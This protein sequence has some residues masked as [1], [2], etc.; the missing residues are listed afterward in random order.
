MRRPR[1]AH[2]L[3]GKI[4]KGAHMLEKGLA[5]AHTLKGVFDTGRTIATA[6]EPL[7]AMM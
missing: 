3:M 6:A 4:Q 2:R 5:F 7:L 1:E